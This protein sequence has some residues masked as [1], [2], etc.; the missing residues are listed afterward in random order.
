MAKTQHWRVSLAD[1]EHEL[2]Y[3][4]YALRSTVTLTIDGE[5]FTL[6]KG[7]RE[8]PFRLGDE[9]AILIIRKNGSAAIRL[10]DGEITECQ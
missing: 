2:T 1:G 5:C 6:P 8:E 4:R 9:Q 3:T 7:E 10:R